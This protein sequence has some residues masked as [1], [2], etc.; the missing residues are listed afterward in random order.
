VTVTLCLIICSIFFTGLVVP[1]ISSFT[2]ITVLAALVC[3]G[4]LFCRLF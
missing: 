2:F 4:L 1:T 3:T